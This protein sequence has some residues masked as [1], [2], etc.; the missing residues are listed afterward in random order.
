M[1][2]IIHIHILYIIHIHILY[3]IHIHILYIM[4]GAHFVLPTLIVS[5]VAVGE[6]HFTQS[7]RSENILSGHVR[8]TL[9]P[10]LGVFHKHNVLICIL[11]LDRIN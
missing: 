5:R 4:C 8:R 10:F 1:I 3:T 2:Y 11:I 9:L 6:T 7:R